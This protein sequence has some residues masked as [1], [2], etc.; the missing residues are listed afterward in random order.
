MD[1]DDFQTSLQQLRLQLDLM[2]KRTASILD[3]SHQHPN[4]V[5][6]NSTQVGHFTPA[7]ADN[8]QQIKHIGATVGA[9]V[10]QQEDGF[11]RLESQL[12]LLSDKLEDLALADP[13]FT[14][15][16]SSASCIS[17]DSEPYS[18]LSS[19]ESSHMPRQAHNIPSATVADVGGYFY[20]NY[21]H[22]SRNNQQHISDALTFVGRVNRTLR[23]KTIDNIEIFLR[24]SALRWFHI[25][26]RIDGSHIFDYENGDMNISKFCQSLI[27]LFGVPKSSRPESHKEAAN[28]VSS[29]MR[30]VII[31][32]YAFPALENARLQGADFDFDVVLSKAIK[33]Y[34]QSSMPFTMNPDIVKNKDLLEMLVSLRCSEFDQRIDK[35]LAQKRQRLDGTTPAKAPVKSTKK[36]G[37]AGNHIQQ[38]SLS[39]SVAHHR[40]LSSITTEACV[41]PPIAK[42]DNVRVEINMKLP[43]AC[44]CRDE[45][46]LDPLEHKQKMR[47]CINFLADKGVENLT[48]FEQKLAA[49]KDWLHKNHSHDDSDYENKL[50]WRR[51]AYMI[52]IHENRIVE[53]AEQRF[54]DAQNQ[55][56]RIMHETKKLEEKEQG[57]LVSDSGTIG[58]P[59][60]FKNQI[61]QA[62]GKVHSLRNRFVEATVAEARIKKSDSMNPG[63]LDMRTKPTV[64]DSVD[65]N[66]PR[67][68]APTAESCPTTPIVPCKCSVSPLSQAPQ[69]R[70]VHE[71]LQDLVTMGLGEVD[72]SILVSPEMA[73]KC[74]LQPGRQP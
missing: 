56:S 65:A 30:S 1:G 29:S 41:N 71:Q 45:T 43:T 44:D 61:V 40:N 35:A 14:P 23:T 24:G 2:N 9:L 57:G 62:P 39:A 47:Q 33:V 36:A 46:M 6:H 25:G 73:K 18:H 67:L 38:D 37:A 64:V 7:M 16:E 42:S 70:D 5:T 22:Y 17:E 11:Q 3:K 51:V 48:D 12:N 52:W 69:I 63:A 74:G 49:L 32:D 21:S 72:Y 13:Q 10:R 34:N 26:L 54:V 8:A 58:G 15:P 68:P 28:L 50:L 66:G 59:K 53:D 19:D 20:P 4:K 60:S 55:D 31:D 27:L